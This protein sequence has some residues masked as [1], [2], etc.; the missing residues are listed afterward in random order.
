VALHPAIGFIHYNR[1]IF[2]ELSVDDYLP[3]IQNMHQQHWLKI[4][5]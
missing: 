1:V 3:T 2:L 4:I 5:Q